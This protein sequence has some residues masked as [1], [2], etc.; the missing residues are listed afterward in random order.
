MAAGPVAG[1]HRITRRPLRPPRLRTVELVDARTHEAHLLTP[2]ALAAGRRKPK[3]RYIALCGADV[4]PA[5]LT[6]A[7]RGYCRSCTAMPAQTSGAS[8]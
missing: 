3:G 2:D 5:S 7:E 6:V 1:K 8:R 4:L